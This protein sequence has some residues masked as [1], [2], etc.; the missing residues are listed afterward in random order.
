MNKIMFASDASSER[1]TS[2]EDYQNACTDF[3]LDISKDYKDW[4]ERYQLPVE[5]TNSRN[6]SID[7]IVEKTNNWIVRY[8]NTIKKV[9]VIMNDG[10]SKM[11]ENTAS[12]PFQFN[13]SSNGEKRYLVQ[14]GGLVRLKI[15][16]IP[17]EGKSVR[18]GMFNKDSLFQVSSNA[19]IKFNVSKESL[20]SSDILD[21]YVT[22]N[23][24]KYV[25]GDIVSITMIVEELTGDYVSERRGYTTI[26]LIQ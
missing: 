3:I 21:D 5:E 2:I 18:I 11:A 12:Y 10:V 14:L 6:G 22:L 26:I 20:K 15:T 4:V 16:A 24:S 7:S 17:G 19:E 25:K 9:D 13:V 8:G 1:A 23:A